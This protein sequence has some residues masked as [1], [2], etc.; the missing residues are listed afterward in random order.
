MLLHLRR[1]V[2][3]RRYDVVAISSVDE[4]E[5]LAPSSAFDLLVVCHTFREF[6]CERIMHLARERWP[7]IKVLALNN[8]SAGS[9]Q[10]HSDMSIGVLDG[11]PAMFAGIS[12][13]LSSR[14]A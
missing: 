12:Q 9:C 13:L 7:G 6:E 3:T 5:A 8:Q 14:A 4:M 2:L 10:D 11:P 1:T